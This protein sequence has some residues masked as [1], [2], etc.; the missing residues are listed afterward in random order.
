MSWIFLEMKVSYQKQILIFSLGCILV[1]LYLARG[2]DLRDMG[3]YNY[4]KNNK[5]RTQSSE[6]YGFKSTMF[7]KL[8]QDKFDM[9]QNIAALFDIC[10]Q[11]IPG[12]NVDIRSQEKTCRALNRFPFPDSVQQF[13]CA[14]FFKSSPNETELKRAM[15]FERELKNLEIDDYKNMTENCTKYVLDRGYILEPVNGEEAHFP[16]AFSILIFRDVEQVERLLRAVYRPQNYYC[17]HVDKKVTGVYEPV[18]L[19]A[20]CLPHVFMSDERY[21]IHWGEISILQAE[22]QCMKQLLAYRWRYFINLTGMEF[23]LKT[24]WELVQILKSVKG[25]NIIAGNFQG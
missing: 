2:T 17:I 19:I 21:Q 13:R 20:S 23:P 12:E 10:T 5:S 18:S 6:R 9:E 16:L 24:N 14:D 7:E 22:I 1:Y 4:F 8:T 3:V 15:E 25:G 11:P